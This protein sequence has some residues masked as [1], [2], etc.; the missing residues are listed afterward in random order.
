MNNIPNFDNGFIILK[1]DKSFVFLVAILNYE[2][3]SDAKILRKFQ[4]IKESE[5][6]QCVVTGNI[7]L[8]A[9]N[10]KPETPFGK[11]QFPELWDYSDGVNIIDFLAKL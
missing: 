7:K 5:N 10:W 9:G 2:F 1:E 6:I 3:Y 8:E 11:T 4:I